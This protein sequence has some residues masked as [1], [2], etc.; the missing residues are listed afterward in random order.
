MLIGSVSDRIRS[1]SGRI[2]SDRIG[3]GSSSDRF[4][5]DR[6]LSDSDLYRI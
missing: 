5:S 4:G 2:G 1:G 3:I 6:N